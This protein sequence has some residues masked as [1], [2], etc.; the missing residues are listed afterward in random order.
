MFY[1]FCNTPNGFMA[2]YLTNIKTFKVLPQYQASA[3]ETCNCMRMHL[4]ASKPLQTCKKVH[5]V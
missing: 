3:Y 2:L 5:L 4:H 1:M